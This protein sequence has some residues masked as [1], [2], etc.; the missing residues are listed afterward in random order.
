[1]VK[2]AGE[3]LRYLLWRNKVDRAQWPERLAGLVECD[4][5]RAE[6]L[7]DRGDLKP[8]EQERAAEHFCVSEEELQYGQLLDDDSTNVLV[9]ILRYLVGALGHGHSKRLASEIG[10]T[11]VTVSR[12]VTGKQV[13]EQSKLTALCRYFGLPAGTDLR[14]EP[15][16]LCRIPVSD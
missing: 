16:F 4:R 8:Y 6:D 13:P 7:L 1:V 11:P 5:A 9:D 15:I 3:N 10:V 12:W 2:S 14:S